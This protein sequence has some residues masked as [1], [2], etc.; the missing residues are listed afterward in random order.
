MTIRS[1]T[2]NRAPA[3]TDRVQASSHGPIRR[4]VGAPATLFGM[5]ALGMLALIPLIPRSGPRAGTAATFAQDNSDGDTSAE[6]GASPEQIEK[7]VAVYRA[8]QRNHSMTVEQAAAAQGMT[9]S[10]FRQLEQSIS[11]DDLSRDTARRALAAP[12]PS[13]TPTPK[14]SR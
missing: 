7:Y 14:A 4:T 12:A 2:A 10:A 6:K 1:S 9:V 3:P 11:S 5:A 8:M 13:A